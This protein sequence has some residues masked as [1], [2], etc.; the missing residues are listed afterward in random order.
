MSTID[1]PGD[2]SSSPASE[3]TKKLSPPS[4]TLV[5]ALFHQALGSSKIEKAEDIKDKVSTAMPNEVAAPAAKIASAAAG[6]GITTSDSPLFIKKMT[7]SGPSITAAKIYSGS[8][9]EV[10]C[11]RGVDLGDD[12]DRDVRALAIKDIPL[13]LPFNKEAYE[14]AKAKMGAVLVDPLEKRVFQKVTDALLHMTFPDLVSGLRNI[15]PRFNEAIGTTPFS[16]VVIKSK[17]NEWVT[18]LALHEGLQPPTEVASLKFEED[19]KIPVSHSTVVIIDDGSYSGSQIASL[20]TNIC[21]TSKHLSTG[22]SPQAKFF[23]LVPFITKRAEETIL[24]SAVKNGV[25]IEIMSATTM[26]TFQEILTEEEEACFKK[27]AFHPKET[28]FGPTLS[29]ADW[30]RPDEYSAP[31]YFLAGKMYYTNSAGDRVVYKGPPLVPEILGP[32]KLT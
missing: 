20:I 9:Y 32:Y 25:E 29:F 23:I 12:V 5:T 16:A 8:S 28:E 21:T 11:I 6:A 14:A 15:V 13:P 2:K 27:M 7:Y 4:E 10:T 22:H 19:V 18:Q 3:V 1:D 30:R 17:S 26:P 24:K 31:T